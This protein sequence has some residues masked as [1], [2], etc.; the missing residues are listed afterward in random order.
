MLL[1]RASAPASP[2]SSEPEEK[3]WGTA[4]RFSH[5]EFWFCSPSKTNTAAAATVAISSGFVSSRSVSFWQEEVI[6]RVN[7]TNGTAEIKSLNLASF[8]SWYVYAS[9]RKHPPGWVL[10]W[11][12][13]TRCC[14]ICRKWPRRRRGG[15]VMTSRLSW[16]VLLCRWRSSTGILT[17][18]FCPWP[19]R[20]QLC[21]AR[22]KSLREGESVQFYKI[23][24]P[25]AMW[26]QITSIHCGNELLNK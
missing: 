2:L 13:L 4:R 23:T 11:R 20:W 26:L 25:V 24:T 16:A 8:H 6:L 5:S 17:P 14:W 18:A 1:S 21:A 9:R 22:R 12:P 7:P 10:W 3:S 19:P 15:P